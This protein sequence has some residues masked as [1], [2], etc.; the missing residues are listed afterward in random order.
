M[1]NENH[2]SIK[3]QKYKNEGSGHECYVKFLSTTMAF[4]HPQSTE[5]M[6]GKARILAGFQHK[7]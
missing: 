3:L 6:Q 1:L 5:Q 2:F 7:P 4:L